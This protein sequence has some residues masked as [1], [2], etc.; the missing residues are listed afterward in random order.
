MA[1]EAEK[2]ETNEVETPGI[3]R[4]WTDTREQVEKVWSDA[5]NELNTR[6]QE[7]EHDVREFVK[8]VDVE[9]RKRLEGLLETL[10]L[11][12]AALFERILPKEAAER[13]SRVSDELREAGVKL[14]GEAIEKLGL[15]TREAVDAAVEALTSELAKLT[16][17]IDSVS[18]KANAAATK[19][20]LAKIEARVAK[21]EAA[22]K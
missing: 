13:A 20:A 19:K 6:F 15:V 8:K 18:R 11:R 7:A 2:N 4:V 1:A 9:G 16:K 17:K 22:E 3:K 5:F 10:K 21:L 12:D 14:G